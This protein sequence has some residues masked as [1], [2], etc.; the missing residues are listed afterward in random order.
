[1]K[2]PLVISLGFDDYLRVKAAITAGP[3]V[4]VLNTFAPRVTN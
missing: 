1:M 4:E 2:T 3:A